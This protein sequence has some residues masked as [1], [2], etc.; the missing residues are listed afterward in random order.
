MSNT[1]TIREQATGVGWLIGGGLAFLAYKAIIAPRLKGQQLKQYIARFTMQ[2][3]G[4]HFK[5]DNLEIDVY[6]QNPNSFPIVIRA[7][8]GELFVH[9]PQGGR[10]KVGNINRYGTTIVKPVSET[11]FV[12][13]IRLRFIELLAY[14]NKIMAGKMRG[15]VLQF[16]G[17][18]NIDGLPYPVNITYPIS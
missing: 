1:L 5:G 3:I 12:M 15:Q 18:I 4:V 17:N 8:V 6:I 7:V 11:K 2:I 13:S 14:F 9:A 16:V 10:L